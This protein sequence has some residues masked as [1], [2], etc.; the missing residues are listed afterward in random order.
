MGVVSA[1]PIMVIWWVI[2]V[3]TIIISVLVCKLVLH[4][5]VMINRGG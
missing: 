2:I 1:M 3:F 4:D 5:Q